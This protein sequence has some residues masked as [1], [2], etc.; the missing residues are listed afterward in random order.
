MNALL[1]MGTPDDRSN[2]RHPSLC[3]HDK[4]HVKSG[5]IPEALLL[6]DDAQLAVRTVFKHMTMCT[7]RMY[8]S[9]PVRQFL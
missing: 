1:H 5:P 7:V 3:S 6:H 9:P 4:I 2:H 8:D